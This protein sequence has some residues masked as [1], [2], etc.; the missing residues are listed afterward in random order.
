MKRIKTLDRDRSVR[1]DTSRSQECLKGTYWFDFGMS[2]PQLSGQ[3]SDADLAVALRKSISQGRPGLFLLLRS[4]GRITVT[5]DHHEQLLANLVEDNS[6]LTCLSFLYAANDIEL[7]SWFLELFIGKYRRGDQVSVWNMSKLSALVCDFPFE[8][9][10]ETSVERFRQLAKEL[11]GHWLGQGWISDASKAAWSIG[12]KIPLREF[13]TAFKS[14]CAHCYE[15]EVQ[16]GMQKLGLKV[17]PRRLA[18]SFLEGYFSWGRQAQLNRIFLMDKTNLSANFAIGELQALLSLAH[19]SGNQPLAES[20]LRIIHARKERSS[21][22][23]LFL[24]LVHRFFQA[25]LHEAAA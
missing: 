7:A 9:H 18:A 12:L 16:Y 14:S 25:G 15:S 5:R 24:A 13:V 6:V 10:S 4:S 21:V 22:K 20:F 23:F 19:E 17:L 2:T 11:I 1:F 8:E 3:Y